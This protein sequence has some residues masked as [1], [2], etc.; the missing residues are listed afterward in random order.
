[1]AK[2]FG[3]PTGGAPKTYRAPNDQFWQFVQKEL[4]IM[5]FYDFSDTLAKVNWNA[6]NISA[7]IIA[8][9]TLYK[10][11]GKFCVITAQQNNAEIRTAVVK[12]LNNHYGDQVDRIYFVSGGEA[13]IIKGKAR[14][15]A[16]QRATSF[17][18]NDLNILRGIAAEL[19]N[20]TLYQALNGERRQWRP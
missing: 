8:A 1:M 7:A 6:D 10:P 20:L 2:P 13:S 16:D 14:I 18:D 3:R 15:L 4:G 12:W 17:T 5:D 11:T 19:P 9:R